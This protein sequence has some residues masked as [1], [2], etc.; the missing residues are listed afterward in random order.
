M[1]SLYNSQSIFAI[2]CILMFVGTLKSHRIQHENDKR[3]QLQK[4][5]QMYLIDSKFEQTKN[6][7]QI[8]DEMAEEINL[9]SKFE[10]FAQRIKQL[11]GELVQLR[12]KQA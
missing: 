4:I 6:L 8:Q 11:E 10:M 2:F 7:L 12:S 5:E 9:L 1:I 3:Q